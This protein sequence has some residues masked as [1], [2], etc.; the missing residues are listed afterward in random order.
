MPRVGLLISRYLLF[1]ILPYFGASWL[2]LSVVLFIQQA[3]RFADIFFGVNVPSD[4]VW[5]L[6]IALIPN[7]IAFT[8]PTA[9]LIGT[10]IGLSK[11]QGDSELITIRSAGVGN[12]QIAIP[13]ILLGILLSIFGYFV[14]EKGV[15]AAAALVKK[16]GLETAIQKL[17]SPL[18]PGAFNTEVAGYTIYVRGG[19]VETGRWT[20]LFAYREDPGNGVVRLLTSKGGRIDSSDE[21]AE[22]VLEDAT[23]VT[24]PLEP[25]D[26][27]YVSEKIGDVRFAIKTPRAEM[28]A[29][30]V[31]RQ[32]QPEELSLSELSAYAATHE[33]RDA[34]EARILWQ[35]RLLL[36]LTPLIFCILGTAMVLRFN[37]GGHGF[38][39]VLALAALVG[40][41][42]LGFL[43]EQMVRAGT[44]PV[45][46]SAALP[47]GASLA[48]VLWLGLVGRARFTEKFGE[49]LG[50][51]WTKL[52]QTPNRIQIK[53][54]FVD[55]TTGLLDFDLLRNLVSYYALTL[56]F[57]FAVFLIFT[58][59]DLWRFAGSFPNGT[60]LL[61]RYLM[62]LSP[63][64]YL[65]ITAPAA[66][67]ATLATYV[68]KSRQ[69]EVVTW[70][71]AGQSVYRL[72]LPCFALMLAIGGVNWLVQEYILPSSN[73]RQD[74]AR[75]LLANKGEP[76]PQSGRVWVAE[77]N[78]IFSYR[79]PGSVDGPIPHTAGKSDLPSMP[80]GITVPNNERSHVSSS[81][82]NG[83]ASNSASSNSRS[84]AS[85]SPA[86]DNA[87]ADSSSSSGPSGVWVYEFE[88]DGARLQ[89]VYR[90]GSA[91]YA[92]GVVSLRGRV[93]KAV[94][95]E[96]GITASSPGETEIP[97]ASDPFITLDEKPGH[98]DTAG[99]KRQLIKA[100]SDTDQRRLGIAIEENRSTLLLPLISALLVAPFSLSLSRKGK[101][102]TVGIAVGLWLLFAGTGAVFER[103]GLNG[104][105]PPAIATWGPLAI[106]TLMGI[107]LLSRVR[108]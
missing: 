90:S 72:L 74:E 41:Y 27:K 46:G 60:V 98:L 15:P 34:L 53:S 42:S 4:L 33:G 22:L 48:A 83:A 31:D 86:S 67:I 62:Y 2:L 64:V 96:R 87:K 59:F 61:G 56:A 8:C 77:G 100:T 102:T 78:Y 70:T 3:G 73:A 30:L 35:R 6:T 43:A 29:K 69:N 38:G 104:L 58:A 23:A 91:E 101:S 82:D 18:E 40:Y 25:A 79:R 14:N 36:S 66:M 47:V 88:D 103:I 11:M 63:F 5:Q 105:L 49:M 21:S 26:G 65:Q 80:F 45:W 92:H 7:V 81:S 85:I 54:M 13:I 94:I 17:E 44:I 97:A 24:L 95:S 68:I 50:G 16:V 84:S 75:E 71:S 19:D 20:G 55:L 1:A 39:T 99:V 108:T 10:V 107:Y 93:E 52:R 51:L 28:I 76:R 57:L 37:R 89:N 32:A 106:F 12:I 9:L